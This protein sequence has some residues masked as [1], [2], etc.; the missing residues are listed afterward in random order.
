MLRINPDG[1][2]PSDNPFFSSAMGNNRAIWALGLRKPFTFAFNPAGP[3]MYY[4]RRRAE[5]MGGNQRGHRRIQLR[6][7]HH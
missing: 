5:H 1:S 3:E 6:M 4:Q 7:A 2:I